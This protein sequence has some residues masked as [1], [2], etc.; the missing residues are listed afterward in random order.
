LLAGASQLA[1]ELASADFGVEVIEKLLA[2]GCG[3]G[4]IRWVGLSE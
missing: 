2:T 4:E 1:A 3:V